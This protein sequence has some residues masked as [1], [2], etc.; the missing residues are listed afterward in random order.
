METPISALCKMMDLQDNLYVFSLKRFGTKNYDRAKKYLEY[1]Y[2][3]NQKYQFIEN[4]QKYREEFAKI[5]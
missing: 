4:I 3:I 1:I 5:E 2:L